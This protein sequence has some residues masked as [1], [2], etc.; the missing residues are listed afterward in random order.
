MF[1]FT[2]KK[3]TGSSGKPQATGKAAPG[4]STLNMFFK[5]KKEPERPERQGLGSGPGSRLTAGSRTSSLLSSFQLQ[6]SFDDDSGNDAFS[7]LQPKKQVKNFKPVASS[8]TRQS[9]PQPMMPAERSLSGVKRTHSSL[10]VF[11]EGSFSQGSAATATTS[12]SFGSI[13]SSQGQGQGGSASQSISLSA[14]KR[15]KPIPRGSVASHASS[16]G[17]K[18]G[19]ASTSLQLTQEQ[20]R[21][22]DYVCKDRLNVFYT[23]SAGTGKSVVLKTIISVLNSK[24][25]K[26]AVAVTASTGLAAVNIGGIT[27]NKFSGVGIGQGDAPRLINMVK[28][29]KNSLQRWKRTKVLIVDEISMIDGVFLDKLDAIGR[30]LLNKSKPFGG[31]QL[32]FTG[33]FFQLPPVPDRDSNKPAP[34]FCFES[35]VW[36]Y[37]IHKTILLQQVFRQTDNELIELLNDIRMGTTSPDTMR[38]IKKFEKP[39]NYD[40]GIEPTELYPTRKEVDLSNKRRLERLP[41]YEIVYQAVDFIPPHINSN[42]LNNVMAEKEIKLK[43]DAQVMMLKNIDDTLVNGSL[44]KVLFFTTTSLF[45]EISKLFPDLSDPEVIEDMRCVCRATGLPPS[46]RPAQ[47]QE[48]INARPTHRQEVLQF[49]LEKASKISNAPGILST[50]MFPVVK[51]ID[52]QDI[53]GY[54]IKLVEP[55]EFTVGETEKDSAIRKQLPPMLC[56]AISIHKSQGQTIDRLKV[57]LKRTFESGQVYVALSRAVSKD[58]LQITNFDASKIKVNEKVKEFYQGLH[59]VSAQP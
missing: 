29:N 23:G 36:K 8:T 38:L 16:K 55:E 5:V 56:W 59:K 3:K 39:V 48:D 20:R 1:S 9:P 42:V 30:G 53:R 58:R 18:T 11:S 7:L 6:G 4:Q 19:G 12:Q 15:I 54:Q 32:V 47:L 2:K 45:A 21:V 50:I 41:G 13:S 27:I 52:K 33:D 44:G 46:G 43:E 31:I 49:L 40:D 57:D 26:D 34:I 28:R 25:G 24:Y 10:D 17:Q 51:F 35:N 37:A 22:I 14:V